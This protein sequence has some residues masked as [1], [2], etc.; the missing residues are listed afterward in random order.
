M[1]TAPQCRCMPGAASA[2]RVPGCTQMLPVSSSVSITT[3]LRRS[4]FLQRFD[5]A[6]CAACACEPFPS[7]K[8]TC[9]GSQSTRPAATC[10]G[11]GVRPAPIGHVAPR[12]VHASA[13]VHRP[14]ERMLCPRGSQ[15]AWLCFA[16][17][18]FDVQTVQHGWT[19]REWALAQARSRKG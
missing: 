6:A 11:F 18:S 9:I 7:T 5:G 13:E 3:Y 1:T 4:Y 12:G 10:R 14:G 16:V 2:L 8:A 17:E 19:L 15:H